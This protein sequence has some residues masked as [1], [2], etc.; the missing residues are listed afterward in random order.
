MEEK[1]ETGQEEKTPEMVRRE[2]LKKFGCYAAGSAMGLYVLM[3][4]KKA[5]AVGS[6]GAP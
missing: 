3:S 5:R 1:N 4:A 6:D 2:F